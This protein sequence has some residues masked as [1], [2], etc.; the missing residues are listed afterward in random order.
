MVLETQSPSTHNRLMGTRIPHPPS[1]GFHDDDDF[2]SPPSKRRKTA[3]PQGATSP[4]RGS[5]R[6]GVSQRAIKNEIPDSEDEEPFVDQEDVALP[7]VPRTTQLE[8]T[9]P[10]V[11]TDE[12]AIEAYEAYKAGEYAD[13]KQK[14]HEEGTTLS[15]LESRSWVRGRSSI[16]VDAFNLALDTVLEEEE[17]LFNRAELKLFKIW[18]ELGYELQYLYVRLFLRK[19]S[20]WFRVKDLQYYSDMTDI[21][22]AVAELQKERPLPTD[23]IEPETFPG[24]LEPPEGSFLGE[25]FSFAECSSEHITSL[26]EASSLL[27]LDEL[28][29]LAKEAKVQGKNKSELLRNLRRTSGRQSGLG[30][31]GFRRTE[32]AE[33]VE[34]DD[35]R[36]IY[37][38]EEEQSSGS[39]TPTMVGNNRDAHFTKKIL[40]QTG[41]CIRLSLT[42]LK[43]FER[44]HLVFYRSTEWTEKSLTT[45]ILAKISRRNFPEYIVSRS[46]TIF[47]SRSLLLEFE[48][49]LRTQFR[50]DNILEFN[51]TPG[52]KS[53]EEVKDI[54]EAVYPRWKVLLAEEQRKEERIY[55]SGEGAYLRRFSPAWVYTRIVHKGLQPLA[56]FKEHLREH[57]ILTELLDQRLFHAARRGAWYQRKALLEEHYMHALTPN[58]NRAVEPNK[59][60]WKRIALKTCEQGLQDKECHV[61][62]H[63]DL[64]KR[65]KKLEKQLHV[66]VREQHDFGHV[67]LGK[68]FE[69]DVVGIKIEK[70]RD[71]T[72]ARSLSRKN[73]VN[74]SVNAPES[75]TKPPALQHQPST[76]GGGK[77]IWLDALDTNEHVSVEAMCLSHYRHIL[78]YKGYHSEGGILRTIFGLL[79]YD[80]LFFNP[81]IPNVFQTAYQTCPLDL[82]TDSFFSSRVPEILGRVNQI[83]NGEAVTIAQQVWDDHF[84][85]KTCIVGVR[86]DGFERDDLFELLGCWDGQA[87]GTVML[88]MAQEYQS[89][90]GGVPDL[91]LWKPGDENG[92]V[93]EVVFSEVKSANDRLSDTQRLWISVL[94]GAGVKVELC[95][96]VAGEVRRE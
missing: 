10:P 60:H 13:E 41:R 50:V 79:F 37:E 6:K 88:V 2:P 75:T 8:A 36:S 44:V 32:T 68:P 28:K 43:L 72:P 86:W 89:R 80:I 35:T 54:F 29:I 42:P 69:R 91:V 85:R 17:H 39:R 40:D 14:Q 48:A 34:S 65:I 61:I 82:H 81:Y 51:G 90:G 26:D 62:Y 3:G 93:G 12:E 30:F 83:C 23:G 16:Y 31:R 70:D 25:K 87:L 24:E 58:E 47:E 84:E 73:S 78:G 21:E 92:S 95:H 55:E 57:L 19:T 71:D 96:A 7:T 66:P 64:Q 9:L 18:R 74:V 45:L 94:L 49:S 5:P 4:K 77:T 20:K 33:S 52:R 59:K 1:T 53:L 11:Q 63:Y 38:E 67:R 15:R 46:T 22:A 76:F 56:R 27:L